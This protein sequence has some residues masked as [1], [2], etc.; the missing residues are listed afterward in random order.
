MAVGGAGASDEDVR[1]EAKTDATKVVTTMLGC[2]ILKQGRDA[3]SG[4][5]AWCEVTDKGVTFTVNE[6]KSL[7]ASTQIKREL[8]HG[9]RLASEH[10]GEQ[11]QERLQFG[12]NLGTL[13]E[14]LRILSGGGGLLD[15]PATLQLCYRADTACLLLVLVE[16]SA[17]TQCKLQTMSMDPIQF[18]GMEG[19]CPVRILLK[20][21]ALREGLAELEWGGDAAQQKDKRLSLRVELE[22]AHLSLTVRQTSLGCEMVYPLESLVQF[23][24]SEPVEHDYRF[25]L[26]RMALRSLSSS[27]ETSIVLG[28][29]GVLQLTLKLK[30]EAAG[31]LFLKFLMFPLIDDEQDEGLFGPTATEA[32]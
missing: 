22:P 20:S 12:L 26:V 21:E 7:Q 11:P 17:V 23:E 16:G 13:V 31:N 18:V 4:P 1:L 24:A 6:A 30:S 28:E 9:W 8:F 32:Q 14:C 10:E 3:S 5:L 29:H 27:D 15:K 2:L 25:A 19:F